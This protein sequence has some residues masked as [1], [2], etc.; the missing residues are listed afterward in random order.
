LLTKAKI[1]CLDSLYNSSLMN[2]FPHVI[3]LSLYEDF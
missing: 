2:F 1:L 3:G